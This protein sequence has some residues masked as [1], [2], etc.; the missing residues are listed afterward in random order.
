MKA[1]AKFSKNIKIRLII[2][3]NASYWKQY[4][5]IGCISMLKKLSSCTGE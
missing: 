1:G 5:E 4:Y 3:I 2:C